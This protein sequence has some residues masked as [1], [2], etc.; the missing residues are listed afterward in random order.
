MWGVLS[1][2]ISQV[3]AVSNTFLI[4]RIDGVYPSCYWC[5]RAAQWIIFFLWQTCTYALMHRRVP[6]TLKE[7][8]W[9][10]SMREKSK[11]KVIEDECSSSIVHAQCIISRSRFVDYIVNWIFVWAQQSTFV[12][13]VERR[14]IEQQQGRKCCLISI[15]FSACFWQHKPNYHWDGVKIFVHTHASTQAHAYVCSEHPLWL[16]EYT[17]GY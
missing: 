9:R 11:F 16:P 3:G 15:I 8:K 2:D 12:V 7:R 6:H 4:W 5:R 1:I 14:M 10:L 13:T 17:A